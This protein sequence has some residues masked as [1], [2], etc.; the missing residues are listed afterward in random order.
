MSRDLQHRLHTR[1]DLAVKVL[2]LPL[3]AEDIE[4]LAVELTPAVKAILAEGADTAAELAP[5]T[6]AVAETADPGERCVSEWAGCTSAIHPDVPEDCPAAL[7][8]LEL[9]R[10]QSDMTYTDVPRPADLVLT[11]RPRT[12]RAWE[13]WLQRLSI[14]TDTVERLGRTVTGTGRYGEVTV[15][16]RGDNVGALLDDEAAQQSAARL[17]GAFAGHPW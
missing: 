11:V 6:Y 16:L 8:A 3:S 4:R 17:S 1:V 9:R 15:H 12:L 13:W 7:L 14:D 10:V 5:I 2:D